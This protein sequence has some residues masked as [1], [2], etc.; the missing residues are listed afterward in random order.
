MVEEHGFAFI[1]PTPEHI[2]LMGD[3]ISAKKA[4]QE[5]GLPVIHGSDGA[6]DS[7]AEALRIARE[8]GYPVLLKASSGG[9]SSGMKVVAEAGR[10][11]E[12]STRR[13]EIGCGVGRERWGQKA[14]KLGEDV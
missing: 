11:A 8:I 5:L 4:A 2:R 13:Q 7:E 6:V 1:G 9:G 3:K 14:E 10:V 12:S